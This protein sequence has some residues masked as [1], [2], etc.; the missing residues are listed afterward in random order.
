MHFSD[1]VRFLAWWLHDLAPFL[2]LCGQLWIPLFW[3]AVHPAI[4]FWRRHPRACYYVVTPS[5][6]LA[7]WSGL[8]LPYYWWLAERFTQSW[9]AV[10]AGLLLNGIDLWLMV[11]IKR[12]LGLR[13]LVGL[14]ELRPEA[15]NA[16]TASSG[17]YARVRHPR[18]LGM[19]LAWLGAVLMSGST[20][21][22]VLVL[23]FIGL[24]WLVMELEERE[25]LKRLGEPYADYRRRVPRLIPRLRA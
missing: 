14:P 7:T 21:L 24:A 3:L 22:L 15:H 16:Q 2:V 4:G 17:V 10:V 9:L 8:L 18:Y 11:Q 6:L 23:V 25:L 19:I 13:V 20:R 1:V 12:V 5:V